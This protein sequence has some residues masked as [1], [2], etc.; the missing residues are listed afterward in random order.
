[1]LSEDTRCLC[2]MAQLIFLIDIVGSK[3]FFLNVQKRKSTYSL[4]FISDD[5]V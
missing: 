3:T 2:H 1:M 5:L 4:K